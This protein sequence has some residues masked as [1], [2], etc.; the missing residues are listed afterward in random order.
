MPP[1]KRQISPHASRLRRHSTDAERLLWSRLRG[2]RLGWKFRFQHTI[3]P[4]VGDFVCLQRM[5]IVEAD[6]GQHNARADRSRT[7]YLRKRGFR[8]IRF[9]N[10]DILQNIDGVVETILIV[11]EGGSD[12]REQKPL[13]RP[14]GRGGAQAEGLGG[15]GLSDSV[16]QTLTS[17]RSAAG[18]SSPAKGGRG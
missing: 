11:L 13:F 1:V 8:I 17:H 14:Y 3:G 18:P 10:H 4:F 15:E 7:A 12:P 6:G 9:W 16:V 5:L 2:R